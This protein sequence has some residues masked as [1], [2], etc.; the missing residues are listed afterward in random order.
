MQSVGSL[1]VFSDAEGCGSSWHSCV[2]FQHGVRFHGLSLS[3]ETGVIHQSRSPSEV[4][5][6]CGLVANQ[7][8]AYNIKQSSFQRSVSLCCAI[9]D[10]KYQ[11]KPSLM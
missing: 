11:E 2:L 9:S 3:L 10:G 1:F 4:M 5:C 7:R 8:K 6:L